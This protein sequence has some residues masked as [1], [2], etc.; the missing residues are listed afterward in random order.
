[1]RAVI[2]FAVACWLLIGLVGWALAYD[3]RL[4]S[5]RATPAQAS[6]IEARS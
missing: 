3:H 1:M 6:A 5:H 2:I 4:A